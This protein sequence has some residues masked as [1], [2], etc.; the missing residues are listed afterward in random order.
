MRNKVALAALLICAFGAQ[1]ANA[2]HR[3]A[4]WY[5]PWPQQCGGRVNRVMPVAMRVYRPDI[6]LPLPPAKDADAEIP[7][8]DLDFKVCGDPDE[9]TAGLLLLRAKMEG[10]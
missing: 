8:P 9:R 7:L 3:F 5:Y 6:L 10:E 2:C 4:R 1:P